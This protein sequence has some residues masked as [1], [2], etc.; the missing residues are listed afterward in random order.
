MKFSCEALMAES[1]SATVAEKN[2][3]DFSAGFPRQRS[4]IT[5]FSKLIAIQS[6]EILV[7]KWGWMKK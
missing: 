5:W 4:D 6:S 1:A 7:G 3:S 2:E